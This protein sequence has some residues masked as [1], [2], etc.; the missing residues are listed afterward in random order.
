M[1]QI[2]ESPCSESC[3]SKSATNCL[4]CS[5]VA[6]KVIIL[7]TTWFIF[8]MN[9]HNTSWCAIHCKNTNSSSGFLQS[10]YLGSA[11]KGHHFPCKIWAAIDCNT[12]QFCP[13]SK[14]ALTY[15]N[16]SLPVIVP[17]IDWVVVCSSIIINS[18]FV[19]CTKMRNVGF[20]QSW[21]EKSKLSAFVYQ[22]NL[23]GSSK[24][25]PYHTTA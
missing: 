20:I 14:H 7:V 5:A 24:R 15:M 16:K 4:W 21:G 18:F 25:S 9:L 22:L 2:P 1:A 11:S 3:S 6:L 13:I 17:F 10:F 23:Q 19:L 12:C 8:S